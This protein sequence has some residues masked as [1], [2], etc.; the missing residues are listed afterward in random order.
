MTAV[1]PGTVSDVSAMFVARITRR[2]AAGDRAILIVG[3]QRSVQRH[4]LD[5]G[6][7]RG[8]DV[9]QRAIDLA[10]RQ[11]GNTSTL[12]LVSCSDPP[13][14]PPR[15]PR[16]IVDLSGYS[17]PGT[18]ICGQPSRK[19]ASGAASQRRRHHDDAQIVARAPRLLRQRQPEIGVDAALV[20]FVEDDRAEAAQQRILLQAARSGCLRSRT[21]RA[22]RPRT[23]LEP[24]VPADF[25]A[26]RPALLLGDPPR[27]R[28]RRD[29]P[30][31]Q[32]DDRSVRRQR[33]RHAR[34]LSRPAPRRRSGPGD[35]A[36]R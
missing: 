9:G 5:A 7:R 22:C 32:H 23:P 1:T 21:G 35:C 12:P 28:P 34:R 2:R 17:R 25:A 27:H 4:D 11:A 24:D 14:P 6:P 20:E 18:A 16:A 3:R 33:R 19:A 10:A 36:P 30:R 29:A 15:L 8:A 31:L 26:E 13:P